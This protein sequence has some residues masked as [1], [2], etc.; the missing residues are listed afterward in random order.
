MI[1]AGKKFR[2]EFPRAPLV[3]GVINV[4]PDS[5]SDGG[6]FFE[7]TA[8]VE[9]GMRLAEAGADILDVGGESTRPKAAPVA[10][11]EELR[12]IIPVIDAL[13]RRLE[14]PVSVDTMKAEVAERALETGAAM[15]NNVADNRND[16]EMAELIATSGAGYIAMHMQGSP[17]TMQSN[18]R[19][20]SVVREVDAFF[21]R[22]LTDLK[23]S[24]V[25][26]EQIALD[27]GIGFGKTVEHN[28]ELL[29]HLENFIHW[30]R[31]MVFGVSRKSFMGKLFGVEVD[32][33]LPASLACAL[34]GIQAGAQVI[35]THDVAETVQAF[36]M[37]QL[38]RE[39]G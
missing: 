2:F 37:V 26:N 29:A 10:A 16:P 22:R 31:P 34:W 28:L 6:K 14:I 13:V 9:Q 4:T 12:R 3:M 25:L 8:A 23:R 17:E 30:D 27:V 33:R 5:F 11:V 19:Y 18:P 1:W 38:I 32:Q 20:E 7:A 24:G 36:R 39:R 35:R 15:V 21:G